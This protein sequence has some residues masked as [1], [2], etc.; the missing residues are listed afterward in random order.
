MD[1]DGYTDIVT[2]DDAGELNIL[3]GG[4]RLRNGVSEHIFTKHLVDNGLGIQVSPNVRNDGGAFYYDGLPQISPTAV[5]STDTGSLDSTK[6]ILDNMIYYQDTYASDRV[7]NSPAAR[8]AILRASI[9]SGS[10]TQD[11]ANTLD[12]LNTG[13]SDV[14]DLAGSGRTDFSTL[15]TS[16]RDFKRTYIRSPYAEAKG[17]KVEKR[18][19][20]LNGGML[21]SGDRIEI[22]LD[23]TNTTPSSMSKGVYLDSNDEHIFRADEG[24]TYHIT[25]TG[26][27]VSLPMVPLQSGDYDNAFE[28]GTLAAGQRVEI[29]Y[30][31]IAMPVA[32]GK[33]YVGLLE[34]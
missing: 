29:V 22:T 34:K 30:T 10:G 32:Y 21:Q 15:D 28:L 5:T 31:V 4:S 26:T 9:G 17:L 12:T 25:K 19:K 1:H 8:N 33:I 3:Y 24:S 18:Y 16:A 7:L 6:A 11:A 13:M 23:L 27:G 20:D 14:I 2:V